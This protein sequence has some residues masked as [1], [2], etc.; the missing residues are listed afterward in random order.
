MYAVKIVL[1]IILI[2]FLSLSAQVFY[3]PSVH[4]QWAARR[5]C[6]LKLQKNERSLYG[7][8]F[9]TKDGSGISVLLSSDEPAS[10]IYCKISNDEVEFFFRSP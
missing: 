3:A 1:L 5:M 4:D 6:L 10:S 9:I 2:V 8:T 7:Q